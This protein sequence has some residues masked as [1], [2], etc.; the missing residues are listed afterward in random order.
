[1][2][3]ERM[4]AYAQ[5]ESKKLERVRLKKQRE[6]WDS[7]EERITFHPIAKETL[8]GLQQ[9]AQST[10]TM[11][12]EHPEIVEAGKRLYKPPKKRTFS[13]VRKGSTEAAEDAILDDS[14]ED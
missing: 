3:L 2:N 10:E 11:L 13:Q 9:L 6:F 7:Y 1:M 5:A 8:Q 14:G 4:E 12:K